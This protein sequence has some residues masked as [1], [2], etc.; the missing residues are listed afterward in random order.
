MQVHSAL[1]PG[2]FDRNAEEGIG[3]DSENEKEIRPDISDGEVLMPVWYYAQDSLE[4]RVIVWV[5]HERVQVA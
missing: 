5:V 1:A 2:A 3:F 4:P